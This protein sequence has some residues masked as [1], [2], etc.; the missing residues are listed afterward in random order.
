LGTCKNLNFSSLP[1]T[2]PQ[3]NSGF[4]VVSV[5]LDGFVAIAMTL[6]RGNHLTGLWA[7]FFNGL[8]V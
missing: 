5:V 4:P 7:K 8:L 3:S 1:G 6:M 2:T